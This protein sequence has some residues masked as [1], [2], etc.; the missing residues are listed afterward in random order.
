MDTGTFA[1][2]ET[3]RKEAEWTGDGPAEPGR[4]MGRW[5]I[6]HKTQRTDGGFPDLNINRDRLARVGREFPANPA[7]CQ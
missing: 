5:A 3:G 1:F 4:G 6:K 2:S 7:V